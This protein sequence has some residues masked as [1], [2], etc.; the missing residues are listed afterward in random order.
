MKKFMVVA[1]ACLLAAACTDP[2]TEVVTRSLSA[3]PSELNFAAADAAPQIVT[4][5]VENV[6]WSYSIAGNE[7]GWVAVTEG[8][9]EL[10]VSVSDNTAE[11]GRDAIL[12]ISADNSNI[13]PCT[14]AI[15]QVAAGAP[16]PDEPGTDEPGTDEP[17]G[18][19]DVST[20]AM[21]FV[22]EGA[23]PQNVEV[24]V[25]GDITWSLDEVEVDWLTTTLTE[26]GFTVSVDD[27][28]ET[29]ERSTVL[30][31]R[32]SVESV[33]GKGI[34]VTQEGREER[35]SLTVVDIDGNPIPESGM[36]FSYN[37]RVTKTLIVTAELGSWEYELTYDDPDNTGWLRVE[38]YIVDGVD[39]RIYITNSSEN[40]ASEP[41]TAKITITHSDP[42]VEPCVVKLTQ[43]GM[44]NF[45]STLLENVTDVQYTG[46]AVWVYGGTTGYTEWLVNCYTSDINFIYGFIGGTG[47]RIAVKIATETATDDGNGNYWIPDGTY[48][49]T[50]EYDGT[51]GTISPGVRTSYF[52]QNYPDTSW[53]FRMDNGRYTDGEAAITEGTMEVSRN[54]EEYTFTFSFKSDAGYDIT[55]SYTGTCKLQ[56][57]GM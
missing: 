2:Q 41:R 15:H 26:T 56:R 43:E 25:T 5:E 16:D 36:E 50:A 35:L 17:T 45:D 47:D 40:T 42:S 57:I 13:P 34:M 21:T 48:T 10:T 29:T 11:E 24:T 20:T 46:G 19:L 4:I 52:N 12:T 30:R 3:S 32:A 18:T 9:T 14:V 39:N 37:G 27:N 23:E 22:G 44:P 38:T 8:E 7:D 54:G 6:E 33:E 1:A 51:P 31:V 55:G 49:V 28:P 53:F